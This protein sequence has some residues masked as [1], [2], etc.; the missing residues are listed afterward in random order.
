LRFHPPALALA[1]AASFAVS[2]A[3]SLADPV[4]AA[5]YPPEGRR[6]SP[7]EV[8]DVRDLLQAALLRAERRGGFVQASER[9]TRAAC[10]PAATAEPACLARL[11]GAGV[12]LTAVV[13]RSA[14]TLLVELKAVDGAGRVHGPVTAG[15]D[16]YL[17]NPEVL[18]HAL[19]KLDELRLAAATRASALRALPSVSAPGRPVADARLAAASRRDGSTGAWRRTAGR[20]STA[21]GVGLL[22]AGALTA[23]LNLRLAADLEDK[24]RRNA[25]EPSDAARYQEVDTN[26]VIAATLLAA[27]G[28]AT[29]T[30]VVL[31]TT[32]PD[33]RPTRGGATVGVSGR[34]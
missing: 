34:F 4:A 19:S 29:V 17:Q 5:V 12:V 25:L 10:G 32:A 13:N 24:Y 23:V 8:S 14:S 11:A 18:V 7:D 3:P 1:F 22:S 27:G 30:G 15:V 16:A 31:W 2:P 33:V 28:V 21:V 6:A 20:W 9:V 26:N